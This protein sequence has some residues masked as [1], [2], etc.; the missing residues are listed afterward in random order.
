MDIFPLSPNH[1]SYKSYDFPH[2]VPM[3]SWQPPR[4]EACSAAAPAAKLFK[5]L[6][7]MTR[8]GAWRAKLMP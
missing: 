4:V 2:G 7:A 5:R 1:I 3:I 6:A 8:A